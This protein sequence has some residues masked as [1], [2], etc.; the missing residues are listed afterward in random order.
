MKR[1]ILL[2]LFALSVSFISNAQKQ[3]S[4]E[5][6]VSNIDVCGQ[7]KTIDNIIPETLTEGAL[8]TVII[9]DD[10]K[11][12]YGVEFKYFR[13]SNRL[14][15]MHREF[16]G[17][18]WGEKKIY[19]K[20]TKQVQFVKVSIDGKFTGSCGGNITINKKSLEYLFMKADFT[21]KYK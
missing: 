11:Y 19:R 10:S 1:I 2:L 3:C 7:I 13:S 18:K 16:A 20:W 12:I 9:Y 4:L 15:L 17:E 14:K 8:A 5:I 21:V 6:K